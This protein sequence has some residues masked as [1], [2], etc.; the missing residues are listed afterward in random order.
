MTEHPAREFGLARRVPALSDF[1]LAG[2]TDTR[3]SPAAVCPRPRPP[4]TIG[5]HTNPTRR[6]T[7]V[8]TRTRTTRRLVRTA[9]LGALIAAGVGLTSTPAFATISGGCREAV[10]LKARADAMYTAAVNAN[11]LRAMTDAQSLQQFAQ[12]EIDLFC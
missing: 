4:A 12:A 3:E 8:N 9:L 2:V 1:R 11:N 10:L 6:R 7:A 5:P